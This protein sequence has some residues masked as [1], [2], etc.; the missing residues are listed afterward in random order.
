MSHPRALL[1]RALEDVENRLRTAPDSLDLRFKRA[2]I[3]EA[4]GLT[5][6]ARLT[7]AGILSRS[8]GDA[9]TLNALGR[10]HWAAGA[11]TAARLA[12]AEAA[13][14]HPDNVAA[15]VNLGY[16]LAY[17]GRFEEARGHYEAALRIDPAHPNAHR[18]MTHVLSE[19]GDEAGA[20][21][22][23]ALGFREPVS[24]KPFLGEGEPVRVLLLCSSFGGRIETD[25]VLDERT[26]ETTTL[27]VEGWSGEAPLPRHD[28]VFNAIA[29]ADRCAAALDT[30]SAL[31][32]GTAAPVVNPPAAVRATSRG[33]SAQRLARIPGVR[34][35]RTLAFD[36]A[37]RSPDE[38][39]RLL[40]GA[41]LRF[42]LLLRSP[43]FHNGRF[44]VKV[45]DARAASAAVSELPG[46]ELLAI[47]YLDGRRADGCYRKYRAIFIDA[48]TYPLHAA[49][50]PEWKIHYGHVGMQAHP[51]RQAEEARF[52]EGIET[53]LGTPVARALDAVREAIGLQY[54]GI[55]FGLDD[56]GN[57]LAYEAN[58]AMNV[59]LPE[60]GERWAAYRIEPAARIVAAA[61]AMLLRLAGR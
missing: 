15:H 31:L 56:A 45:E 17:D 49:I 21:V 2:E 5:D 3:L 36:R 58:A 7:Y 18:G 48:K 32:R 59:V 8:P 34:A 16:V 38:L 39:D 27:V 19:L 28:L 29:D 57:V 50:S 42:P 20:G 33:A 55:D 22:H 30:A 9:R 24:V 6:L 26:F 61:R 46:P 14:R 41:G 52:L 11:R 12:F 4:L 10:L 35:P 1:E 44:F 25:R 54:G 47:E 13:R 53:A 43:G 37:E 51:E 40:A 23:R 60:S